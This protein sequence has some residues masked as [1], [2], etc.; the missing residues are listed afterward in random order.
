MLDRTDTDKPLPN[1]AAGVIVGRIG[2]ALIHLIL[3]RRGLAP[4]FVPPISLILATH[5]DAYIAALTGYR[6]VGAADTPEAQ[7]GMGNCID[8]FVADT[9]RACSDAERFAADLDLLEEQWRGRIG[10][11]RTGSSVDLLLR[12]LPSAP[13][14]TVGTAAQLIGRSVQRANDAV[15]RLVEA[16]IL[17]QTTV[18]RRNRAFEAPELV[19]ALTGFERAFASPM[20]DICQAPPARPVPYRA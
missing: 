19:N 18:G 10:R 8:R 17:K 1:G 11:I 14:L 13:V 2:N 16:Q 20:G 5:A 9:A 4:R 12:A 7:E 15:N 3:R 6:Y